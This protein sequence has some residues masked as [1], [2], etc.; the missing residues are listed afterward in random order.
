MEKVTP[1]KNEMTI[2]FTYKR[3]KHFYIGLKINFISANCEKNYTLI[4]FRYL[5]KQVIYKYQLLFFLGLNAFV[6]FISIIHD[7]NPVIIKKIVKKYFHKDVNTG[8]EYTIDNE[9]FFVVIFKTFVS[10]RT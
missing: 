6:F 8:L 10:T 3:G 7:Q 9:E 4:N 5:K 2:K 1:A